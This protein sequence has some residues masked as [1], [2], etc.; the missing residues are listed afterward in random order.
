MKKFVLF[1]MILALLVL[2]AA[3]FQVA[4]AEEDL[5]SSPPE[6]SRSLT[7][8][9]PAN[10]IDIGLGYLYSFNTSSWSISFPDQYG[11]GK[12]A[13]DFKGLSSGMPIL[14]LDI[15][16]PNSYVSLSIQYGKG[17]GSNGNGT[18]SDSLENYLYYESR[19]DVGEDTAFWTADIQ[20]TFSTTSKRR[21]VFTPFIGWQHY[22]EKV[23]MTNGI[24]TT[25]EGLGDNTPIYGLNSSYEFTWNALQVGMKGEWELTGARQSGIIPLRLKCHLALFPYMQYKGSGVWNLREDFKQNPSF[26][27]EAEQWGFLGMNGGISLVY[28]PLKFLEIEGGGRISYFYIQNGTDTTFFSD[29]TSDTAT[30]DEAKALQIGL[31]L[32]MTWRF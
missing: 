15:K 18:D 13:L 23:K 11:R 12:S 24:W 3:T 4:A 27:H 17:Q 21:W 19:F 8:G 10:V 14:S 16:H 32:Q 28:Q 2:Q 29:N 1:S 31:F 7:W 6:K 30:L 25:Y 26:S 22:E 20:T 9:R 5:P